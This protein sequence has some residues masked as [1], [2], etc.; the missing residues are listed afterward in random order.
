MT[1]V[2]FLKRQLSGISGQF[3]KKAAERR[4]MVMKIGICKE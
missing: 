3:K 1:K 4:L 2:S